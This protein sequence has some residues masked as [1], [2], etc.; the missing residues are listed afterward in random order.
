MVGLQRRGVRVDVHAADRVL[1]HMDGTVRARRRSRVVVMRVCVVVRM[2]RSGRVGM[3]MMMAAAAGAGGLGRL[4]SAVTVAAAAGGCRLLRRRHGR[5]LHGRR[6]LG[7]TAAA[8]A[9]LR[10]LVSRLIVTVARHRHPPH[11]PT[12]YPTLAIYTP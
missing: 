6:R 4:V 3:I 1:G 11:T 9:A 2:G 5:C 10:V 12:G 7:V 8:R